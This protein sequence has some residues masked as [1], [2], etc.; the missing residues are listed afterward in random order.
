MEVTVEDSVATLRGKVKD[1]TSRVRAEEAAGT[2]LGVTRIANR[3]RPAT[4]PSGG[5]D[6]ASIRKAVAE[7][8]RNYREF[9]FLGEIEVKVQDAKVTLTGAL[10]L[11]LGRQQAGTM[12][13]LVG[14]V[15]EVDN[16]IRTEPGLQSE[17]LIVKELP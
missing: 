9:A 8:L 12:V 15:R 1:F 16:R 14:G 2:V 6:D 4:A 13:A 10:P 17:V 11:F 3:L 7:Y 5:P